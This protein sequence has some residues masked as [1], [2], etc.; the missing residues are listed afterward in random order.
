MS[1]ADIPS[2]TAFLSAPDAE[3]ARVA[4]RAAIF[5]AGGTRRRAVLDGYAA[6]SEDYPSVTGRQMI[7]T[8]AR[9]F[10]LGVQHLFMTAIRPGQLAEVGRYRERIIDWVA[11]GLSGPE[12]LAEFQRYGWAARIIGTE[13]VPELAEAAERMRAA[14]P[15][16]AQHTI[17]WQVH[18]RPE[19]AWDQTVRILGQA[20][21]QT[22]AEAIV[23]LYGQPIPPIT[24]YVG[25]GKPMTA[26]DLVPPLLNGEIQCY[27]LQRPGIEISEEALR[28]IFYDYAYLRRTWK[29]DKR[30]RYEQIIANRS[31]WD[32]QMILGMGRKLGDFWYPAQDVD[33]EA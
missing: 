13:S 30:S 26:P 31:L 25:F 11:T 27:W 22:T 10:R 4:P 24:L 21:A 28:K 16:P 14:T 20:G 29:A 23:A 8:I 32:N 6:D 12:V 18:A 1:S 15:G 5:A 7:E 19:S 17:W 33:T 9:F 2:L 3:V